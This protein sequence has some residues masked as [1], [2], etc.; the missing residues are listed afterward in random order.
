MLSR[1]KHSV[2]MLAGNV[3]EFPLGFIDIGKKY[4]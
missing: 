3:G 2:D 4:Y 1:K